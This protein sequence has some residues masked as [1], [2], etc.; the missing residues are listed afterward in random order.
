M[1]F[2]KKNYKLFVSLI[3]LV[4]I[5]FY[6]LCFGIK[7]ILKHEVYSKPNSQTK[8]Y[9][10]WHT[11]TFEGGGKSRSIYL[12]KIISAIE[13]ENKDVLFVFVEIKPENLES[14]LKNSQPDI[15]S[16]GYG[17]GKILLTHLKSFSECYGV[18]DSF[19]ESGSFSNKVYALPFMAGGYAKFEHNSHNPFIYGANNFTDATKGFSDEMTKYESQYLAYKEFVNNKNVSLVGT[20]R[21]L[22]RVCNLNNLGRINARIT[23]L[24]NYTDLIQ[25]IGITNSDKITNKFVEMA[26]KTNQQSL[27]DYSL[28]GVQNNKLYS[29]D[30]YNDMENAIFKAKIPNCFDD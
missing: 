29:S 14:M 13:K 8:I 7:K 20:S 17:V 5:S 2:F 15:I 12:K 28:F 3:C 4:L 30:I 11:E 23:P 27:C 26:C 10:V 22:F 1:K 6:V 16:F 19:I 18:R 9:T 24:D 21:D 25:Y